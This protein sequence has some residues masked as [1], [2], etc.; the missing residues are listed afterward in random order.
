MKKGVE[1]LG[2]ELVLDGF[3]LKKYVKKLAR[4]LGE[5]CSLDSPGKVTLSYV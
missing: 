5:V 4:E 3:H 1:M 2:A